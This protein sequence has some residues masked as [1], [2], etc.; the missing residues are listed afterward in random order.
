VRSNTPVRKGILSRGTLLC[1]ALVWSTLLSAQTPDTTLTGK[2]VRA[3]NAFMCM[4]CKNVQAPGTA[5]ACDMG[6]QRRAVYLDE[7]RA[8]FA[9]TPADSTDLR[10]VQLLIGLQEQL[11]G[12]KPLDETPEAYAGRRDALIAAVRRKLLGSAS[13]RAAA[14]QDRTAKLDAY[15]TSAGLRELALP[16]VAAAS[17]AVADTLKDPTAMAPDT[18]MVTPPPVAPPLPATPPLEAADEANSGTRTYWWLLLA[19]LALLLLWA[20]RGSGR[21]PPPP[22]PPASN[23]DMEVNRGRPRIARTVMPPGRQASP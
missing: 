20:V 18:A 15:I 2:A 10:D 12:L 6:P 21:K 4:L 8:R 19:P 9:A 23:L 16:P 22:P 13:F 7:L 17:P 3:A 5:M 1:I 11:M 14:G